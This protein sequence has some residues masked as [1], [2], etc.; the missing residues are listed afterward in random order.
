MSFNLSK[1]SVIRSKPQL[2][3]LL[4]SKSTIKFPTDRPDKLRTRIYEALKAAAQHEEFKKYVKIKVYYKFK[5]ESGFLVAKYM[6]D[7]TKG[8]KGEEDGDNSESS[9]PV[10]SAP[11]EVREEPVVSLNVEKKEF[12]EAISLIDVLGTLLGNLTA[13]ELSFPN[14]I[15]SKEEKLK[16]FGWT[17]EV[18]N[19]L[20]R[21]IDM[22]DKG[23]VLTKEEVPI[24]I[25]WQPEE[26]DG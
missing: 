16:L 19:M 5:I 4:E 15:L 13:H 9:N 10:S 24:D 17:K 6:M 23:I 22:D 7:E 14:V 18:D 3:Q 25:L 20:W 2:D 8:V 21:F 12:P 11:V 26:E 1:N